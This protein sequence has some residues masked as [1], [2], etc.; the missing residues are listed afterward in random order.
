M[1]SQGPHLTLHSLVSL[2]FLGPV[3]CG[4]TGG[5]G[6]VRCRRTEGVLRVPRG[7][8]RRCV[9]GDPMV[10]LCPCQGWCTRQLAGKGWPVSSRP[11]APG[12]SWAARAGAGRSP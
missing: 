5:S 7:L 1:A 9:P 4:E 10:A 12:V 2:G 3:Q 8:S 6:G 11:G